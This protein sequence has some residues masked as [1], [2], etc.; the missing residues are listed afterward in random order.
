MILKLTCSSCDLL[1]SMA[2]V[3]NLD[4]SGDKTACLQLA[5]LQ[6]VSPFVL[7]NSVAGPEKTLM[8][9]IDLQ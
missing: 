5:A 3:G 1:T 6:L 2:V 7:Q 4:T 8:K 9:A